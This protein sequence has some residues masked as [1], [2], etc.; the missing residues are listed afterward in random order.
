MTQV[1]FTLAVS[2]TA[3]DFK[4]VSNKGCVSSVRWAITLDNVLLQNPGRSTLNTFV[5]ARLV[6]YEEVLD[7]N[8]FKILPNHYSY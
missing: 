4:V 1:N 6:N 3:L 5:T 7:E 2:D 8:Y